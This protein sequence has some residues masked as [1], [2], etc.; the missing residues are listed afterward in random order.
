MSGH[1]GEI[2]ALKAGVNCATVLERRGWQLDKRDSTQRCWKYRRG[3]G[4]VVIVNHEG[5][6]WW[7]ATGSRKGDVFALVQFLEPG[8]SF[9]QVRRALRDLCGIAPSFPVAPAA[10]R[11][12]APDLPPA[13]RWSARR[14][15]SRGSQTWRY[16]TQERALLEPVL[17]AASRADALRE[18]PYGSAWF[19]HRD[20]A[21]EVVGIEMRG[22]DCRRFSAGGD[23]TLFQLQGWLPSST[24][25]ATR[26]AVC[27][28]P[29]DAM[30][31]AG[32]ERLRADTLY[33]ATGGGM[34]PETVTALKVL[35][36]AL[37]AHPGA[38][39]V[40]ATD[41]DA[42]GMRYAAMLA[43]L[44]A[45]AGVR[46]GRILPFGGLNDWNDVAQARRRAVPGQSRLTAPETSNQSARARA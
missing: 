41:A 35:L 46:T 34:G 42:P 26:L 33:V 9:G 12:K 11:D 7:D 22:P 43:A 3:A 38:V 8:T 32:I 30:S 25:P 23:K 16:L 1:D 29:I 21:G 19:A 13:T 28:A 17:I 18:G 14:P 15:L 36:H 39:L 5:R 31:L 45:E 2:E 20:G 37:A 6:G 44:A 10:K 40:Q 24:V 4:E 27:E